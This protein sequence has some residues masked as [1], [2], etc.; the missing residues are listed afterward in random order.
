MLLGLYLLVGLL[1]GTYIQ[2]INT[3]QLSLWSTVLKFLSCLVIIALWYMNGTGLNDYADYEIDLINL[4]NDPDRPLVSGLATREELSTLTTIYA[5]GAI[6]IALAL[7]P[8]HA[9][10]VAI[11]LLL[12][13][14]YS[15]RP[16]QLSRRGGVAPLLLPLGYV[17]LP[18][19]LGYGLVG[20]EI[21]Q[22]GILLLIAL[23]LQ[24]MG[25]II[26]K[27]YRDVK[28][29]A[30]YGKQTFLL[31]FGNRAVCMVS[32]V[33]I[34]LGCLIQLIYLPMGVLRYPMI[35]LTTYAL[36]ILYTLSSTTHW[37]Q[38]KPLLAAFGRAMTGVT[39]AL[40]TALLTLLWRFSSLEII[41]IASV[42]TFIYLWSA[43]EAFTYNSR[44]LTALK[45][46]TS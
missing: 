36:T 20:W 16:L 30:T 23:Y 43:Q 34:S 8:R 44:R 39:V 27:D 4:K 38:Q 9:G 42:L 15:V 17:A 5:V 35:A 19:L 45:K 40:I 46:K 7:S 14:A 12:N 18:Y 33:G 41:I 6:A 31:K 26:L 3:D 32:G 28:G 24:F 29:D 2:L 1:S 37:E 21:P 10:L 22:R 25:R 11:L 13:H